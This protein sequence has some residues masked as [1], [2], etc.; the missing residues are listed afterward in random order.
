MKRIYDSLEK[1]NFTPRVGGGLALLIPGVILLGSQIA[2]V[3]IIKEVNIVNFVL[4]I[5][6]LIPIFFGARSIYFYVNGS[7]KKYIKES[8]EQENISEYSLQCDLRTAKRIANGKVE[9]GEEYIIMYG[10]KPDVGRYHDIIWAFYKTTSADKK[11]A[12]IIPAGKK[13]VHKVML[14][15]EAHMCGEIEVDSIEEADEIIKE[16]QK[17][18]PHILVG[19]DEELVQMEKN[20]FNEMMKLVEERKNSFKNI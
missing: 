15:N 5:V 16:L 3:A 11:I 19:L 4:G 6:S 14:I 12:G 13:T 7:Y 2:Y 17:R 20:D 18:L 8:L 1:A 9:I 10:D